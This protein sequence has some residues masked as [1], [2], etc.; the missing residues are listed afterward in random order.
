MHPI[1][2]ALLLLGLPFLVIWGGGWLL[3]LPFAPRGAHVMGPTLP[4]LWLFMGWVPAGVVASVVGFL[5]VQRGLLE[6]WSRP[7]ATGVVLAPVVVVGGVL[8]VLKLGQVVG[9]VAAL[10]SPPL[11]TALAGQV[12]GPGDVGDFIAAHPEPEARYTL[13]AVLAG[14]DVWDRLEVDGEVAAADL[15]AVEA[16][17]LS[18]LD[19]EVST[20]REARRALAAVCA[21]R[22]RTGVVASLIPIC[23]QAA[24]DYLAHLSRATV[25]PRLWSAGRP[26]LADLEALEALALRSEDHGPMV[27]APQRVV[28][29]AR[30]ERLVPGGAAALLEGLEEEGLAAALAV[31]VTPLGTERLEVDGVV[32]EADLDAIEAAARTVR[33]V[34]VGGYRFPWEVPG[35]RGGPPR[36]PPIDFEQLPATV[37]AWVAGRRPT[38]RP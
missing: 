1:W 34:G 7:V 20:A 8:L 9:T 36:A 12:L 18:S 32:T 27:W 23:E 15:D 3:L 10:R 21:A 30:A 38:P 11:A 37:L 26:D 6:P 5:G 13:L 2:T 31:L 4:L 22:T 35:P 29:L 14:Q 25:W 24:I 19:A 33:P 28:A 17:A 16:L